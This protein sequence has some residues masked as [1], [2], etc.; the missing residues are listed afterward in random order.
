MRGAIGDFSEVRNDAV[1]RMEVFANGG[2]GWEPD[3][4]CF[5][6]GA[7]FWEQFVLQSS[8]EIAEFNF[9]VRRGAELCSEQVAE[10]DASAG[11]IKTDTA[12]AL[13]TRHEKFGLLWCGHAFEREE[14]TRPKFLADAL[15]NPAG[16]E[17]E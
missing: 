4:A 3:F 5:Q 16:G 6:C 9:A 15:E 12:S 11:V 1:H 10:T 2:A 17:V 13:Q 7:K 14:F 8:G